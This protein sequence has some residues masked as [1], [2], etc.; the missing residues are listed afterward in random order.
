MVFRCAALLSA[1][2]GMYGVTAYSQ[3]QAAEIGVS[4]VVDTSY[5]ESSDNNYEWITRG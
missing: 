5:F 1:T 3:A 2:G 4:T